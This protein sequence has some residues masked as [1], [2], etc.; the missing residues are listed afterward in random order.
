[1]K[2]KFIGF[3]TAATIFGFAS[4]AN[5]ATAFDFYAGA[6][7]GAGGA[8]VFADGGNNTDSGMSG[9]AMVG[10][11]IP[12]FR[13]EAEY[14]Y[15]SDADLSANAAM[16]NVYFKMPSI[17]IHPYMGLGLGTVFGGDVDSATA[18][19]QGMLGLTFDLPLDLKADLEAR[20]LYA[21]NF[22]KTGGSEPDLLHYEARVKLRFVF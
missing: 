12:L 10:L 21:P 19:Y 16:A 7:L 11:D 13:I 1:M 14:N 5:A 17:A 20:A 4:N 18:A 6:S 8:T 3:L 9:G 2:T 15:L 22:V